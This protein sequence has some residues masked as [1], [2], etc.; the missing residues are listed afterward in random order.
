MSFSHLFG[1]PLRG[2]VGVSSSTLSQGVELEPVSDTIQIF[3]VTGDEP[4]CV[5][6][7][8]LSA[9]AG[10]YFL[11]R[12]QGQTLDPD[13]HITTQ[14]ATLNTLPPGAVGLYACDGICWHQVLRITHTP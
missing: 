10:F 1:S 13:L 9:S 12:N 5:G 2:P 8:A 7:P 11:I 14:L 3:T 6:L 4:V